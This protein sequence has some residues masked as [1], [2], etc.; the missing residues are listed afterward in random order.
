MLNSNNCIS[1]EAVYSAV[2]RC[3]AVLTLKADPAWRELR[4]GELTKRARYDSIIEVDDERSDLV[5]SVNPSNW[6]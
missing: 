5:G 6:D 3:V 4:Y 1:L 2:P